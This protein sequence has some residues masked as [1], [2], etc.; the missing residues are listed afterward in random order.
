MKLSILMTCVFSLFVSGAALAVDTTDGYLLGEGDTL[1]IQVFDENEL[2]GT[3]T[4]GEDG[5]I[6][7]PLLGRFEVAGQTASGLDTA[8]TDR[9]GTKYLREPQIQVSVSEFG[10]H[11]VQV[12]GAVKKPGLVHL[13]GR[14]TVLDV[15]AEAGGVTGAGVAEV[16]VKFA[17]SIRGSVA[18]SLEDLMAFELDFRFCLKNPKRAR[19]DMSGKHEAFESFLKR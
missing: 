7:Y 14:N 3:F 2:S 15:I 6:D 9:L 13:T 4:I 1:T 8:L 5:T 16:R 18:L 12:L 10:S 19:L 17:D 11:P